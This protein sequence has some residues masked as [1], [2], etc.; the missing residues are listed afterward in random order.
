MQACT[1]THTHTHTRLPLLWV[2][3][4]DLS[5]LVAMPFSSDQGIVAF[6]DSDLSAVLILSP[7]WSPACIF[8]NKYLLTYLAACLLSCFNCV[9]LFVTLWTVALQA[10]LSMGF[11]RQEDWSGLPWPPP[12]GLP[13][14][15]V[16]PKSL[17]SRELAGSLP[18]A[19]PGKP[20]TGCLR[21]QLQH[22]DHC[23]GGTGSGALRHKE[24]QFPQP[25][26]KP[27]FPALHGGFLT[28]GPP[29]SLCMH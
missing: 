2:L 28:T 18:L 29:R 9:R 3:S 10:P 4:Y 8:K 14:P 13:D 23:R 24:T 26:V 21:S 11:S 7:A 15:G 22:T 16:K 20:L 19:P 6:H 12:G 17:A 27:R 1:H 5:F 25:S